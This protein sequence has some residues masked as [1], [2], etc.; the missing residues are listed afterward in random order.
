MM[1][2]MRA[3]VFAIAAVAAAPCVAAAQPFGTA[4]VDRTMHDWTVAGG[5]WH[6]RSVPCVDGTVTAVG[7]RLANPGQTRFTAQDYKNSGVEI[8]VRLARPT[9]FLPGMVRGT[10]AVVHYQ[11]DYDNAFIGG[12]KRGDRVQVCLMG[13]PTP[14][15]DAARKQYICNPDADPRGW[16]F[17]MYDYR[18][19][20]AFFG[21]DT[22]HGCGGA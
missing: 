6:F 19:H 10:A 15:Y 12:E 3:A 22:E 4:P 8:E 5:P 2:R 9:A 18:R 16:W 7:P 11:D 1:K 21:P 20:K 13:F 17:R 14:T